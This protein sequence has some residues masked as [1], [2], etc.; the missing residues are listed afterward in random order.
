MTKE[1]YNHEN[2]FFK[3][4]LDNNY[5]KNKALNQLNDKHFKQFLSSIT[6]SKFKN[7]KFNFI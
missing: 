3:F 4:F 2:F 6:S 1:N 5:Y 7:I